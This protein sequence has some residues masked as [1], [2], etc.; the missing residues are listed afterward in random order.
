MEKIR[1]ALEKARVSSILHVS[2]AKFFLNQTVETI[3]AMKTCA[4]EELLDNRAYLLA[5][6]KLEQELLNH[7]NEYNLMEARNSYVSKRSDG[8]D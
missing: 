5:L 1:A 8:N 4:H 7:I 3:E 2:L 6:S